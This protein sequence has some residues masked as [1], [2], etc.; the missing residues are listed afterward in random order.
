MGR[1][2][3]LA[4]PLLLA[5]LAGCASQLERGDAAAAR[6]DWDEAVERYQRALAH[7][8]QSPEVQSKLAHATGLAADAHLAAAREHLANGRLEPA[9]AALRHSLGFREDETARALLERTLD[10]KRKEDAAAEVARAARAEAAGDL[11]A[12]RAAYERAATLDPERRDARRGRDRVD[13]RIREAADLAQ[14]AQAAL[15]AGRLRGAQRLASRALQVHPLDEV[16]AEVSKTLRREREARSAESDAQSAAAEGDLGYAV[17]RAREALRLRPTAERRALAAHLEERAAADHVRRGDAAFAA[18]QWPDAVEHYERALDYG[19]TDPEV[20]GALRDARHAREV[21]DARRAEAR[22]RW[23]EALQHYRKAYEIRASPRVGR[24]IAQLEQLVGDPV[25]SGRE[26]Y[27]A[28]LP[29]VVQVRTRKGLASGVV[30]EEGV[31]LTH[32]RALDGPHGVIATARG[33]EL[34]YHGATRHRHA[35]VVV[36]RVPG[37]VAAPARLGRGLDLRPGD[38]VYVIANPKGRPWSFAE[39]AVS[40]IARAPDR[41]TRRIHLTT[42]LAPGVAGAPV[43]NDRGELIG[44]ATGP[45]RPGQSASFAIPIEYATEVP[46][47]AR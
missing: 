46:T 22:A 44:L 33:Q 7:E 41:I 2:A 20:E 32:A 37:L 3:R 5:G 29:S 17:E 23:S 13:A 34:P 38:P 25:L 47:A 24:K 14:Q 6:G 40:A 8:P 1:I 26:I 35:D 30:V 27:D 39:G 12:A 19:S 28:A 10:A 15:A 9:I 42:P 4:L 11:Q 16:A 31:V 43:F 21:S 36:I 18:R 45:T